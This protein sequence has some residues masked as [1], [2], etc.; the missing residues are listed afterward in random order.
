MASLFSSL[1]ADP[2]GRESSLE[3]ETQVDS[4]AGVSN[5]QLPYFA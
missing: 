1:E 3:Y 4:A 2:F 5:Q